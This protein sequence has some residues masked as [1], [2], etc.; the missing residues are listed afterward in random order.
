MSLPRHRLPGTYHLES[1]HCKRP[2]CADRLRAQSVRLTSHLRSRVAIVFVLAST[3]SL[4]PASH[5]RRAGR[6]R[7]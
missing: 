2:Q 7:A 1:L 5:R 3:F 4:R 6:R